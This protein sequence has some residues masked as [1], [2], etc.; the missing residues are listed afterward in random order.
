[1]KK[2]NA[3]PLI[4]IAL[5]L[6]T[7]QFASAQTT[8]FSMRA[9]ELRSVDG[10]DLA[11]PEIPATVITDNPTNN[12]IRYPLYLVKRYYSCLP[13]RQYHCLG[14][15]TSLQGITNVSYEV[16]TANDDDLAQLVTDINHPAYGLYCLRVVICVPYYAWQPG[17]YHQFY[18]R[19]AYHHPYICW[20]EHWW[21]YWRSPQYTFYA[22]LNGS[23]EV[24]PNTSPGAGVGQFL[25]EPATRLFSYCVDYVN[26]T[27][28]GS[29]FTASHVH[30]P[31]PPGA[32]AGVLFNLNPW[33]LGSRSGRLL[34]TQTLTTT[35]ESYLFSG[36][37][38]ANIHS[39][40]F[41]GGEIRGQ[42][43]Q[44][45]GPIYC[46]WG[47]S[48]IPLLRWGRG[49]PLWCL[50][51]T[52]PYC[53]PWDP[54]YRP[55]PFCIYGFRYYVP[56]I[57]PYLVPGGA[58]PPGLRPPAD[59]VVNYTYQPPAPYPWI[60]YPRPIYN[61]WPYTPYCARW[62]WWSCLPFIQYRWA[63]PIVQ[64]ATWVNPD[65]TDPKVTTDF[66]ED[67]QP[68]Y[69]GT[70]AITSARPMYS[71]PADIPGMGAVNVQALGAYREQ[72]NVDS[73]FDVFVTLPPP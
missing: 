68:G 24:G 72:Q 36:Q 58:V 37:L 28:T 60:Y 4:T 35:H 6:I 10:N 32:N 15:R 73:F 66:P 30:G 13:W 62:Y 52:H 19:F 16:D 22:T 39:G 9:E 46:P 61:Y 2:S 63:S 20:W 11:K 18:A 43:Q 50:T 34:G 69:P 21:Y 42:I 56:P 41:G 38:Y 40:S 54:W 12:T 65:P 44:A 5:A 48:W 47:P 14:V 8:S 55:R 1:M 17:V 23:Q 49:G 70:M 45:S 27:N 7:A 29:G 59:Q 51:V 64:F 3:L 53:Y 26:L 33:V 25:Y 67:P 71:A 31:A 57:G